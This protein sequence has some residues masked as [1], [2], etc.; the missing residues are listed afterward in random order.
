MR[1]LAIGRTAGTVS[2]VIAALSVAGGPVSAATLV[3]K[4]GSVVHGD[5]KT[6]QDSV[7]TVET[8]ALGTVR[9]RQQD[10]RSIDLSDEPASG[11]PLSS[12]AGKSPA[13]QPAAV[14]DLQSQMMQ[15]PGLFS[16]IQALQSDPE[17][18]AVLSDPEITR[19]VASGDFAKLMNNPKIIA[20]LGNANV[21]E[22]ID[23]V[24]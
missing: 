24:Q 20:L 21:R 15:I 16:M 10:I 12:S 17:V 2:L 14:Q 8:D 11:T 4:D 1:G 5:I 19:A 6:L 9:V 7:Y 3:L 23:E 18:Q 22:V 13:Q